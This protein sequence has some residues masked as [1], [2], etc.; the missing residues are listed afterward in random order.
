[1]QL[2]NINQLLVL[3]AKDLFSAETQFLKILSRLL[4]KTKNSSLKNTLQLLINECMDN[5]NRLEEVAD[6]LEFNPKGHVSKVAK[7]LVEE[8]ISI[9]LY[10][11]EIVLIDS[12][13]TQLLIKMWANKLFTYKTCANLYGSSGYFTEKELFELNIEFTQSRLD[14]LL[15]INL[16]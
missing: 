3:Q 15:E 2:N 10:K 7:A 13:I 1:M 6:N 4:K 8:G 12:L 5:I 16:I 9:I 14:K 11:G